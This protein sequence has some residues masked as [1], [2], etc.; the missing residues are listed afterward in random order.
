MHVL[1]AGTVVCAL[2][3]PLTVAT[4]AAVLGLRGMT[5]LLG[6]L[7]TL[8]TADAAAMVADVVAA[9]LQVGVVSTRRGCETRSEKRIRVLRHIAEIERRFGLLRGEATSCTFDQNQIQEVLYQDMPPL[10]RS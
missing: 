7:L 6:W 3:Y 10:L 1:L 5:G 8:D 4:V 2:F 9:L